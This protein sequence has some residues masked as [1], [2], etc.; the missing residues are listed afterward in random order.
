MEN[1]GLNKTELKGD[2]SKVDLFSDKE[3]LR[4]AIVKK[5]TEGKYTSL[6]RVSLNCIKSIVLIAIHL[7]VYQNVY[8]CL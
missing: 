7:Q 4:I 2:Y 6:R 5:E 1:K 8:V 3:W